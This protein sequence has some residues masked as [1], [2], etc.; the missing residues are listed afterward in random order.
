M[1]PAT[2][3]NDKMDRSFLTAS[4]PDLIKQ[5]TIPEKVSLLAGK[6]WWR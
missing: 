2:I 1:A 3:T 5:M 4:I 6:D